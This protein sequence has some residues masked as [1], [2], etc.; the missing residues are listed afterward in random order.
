MN[1]ELLDIEAIRISFKSRM[2]ILGE[3]NINKWKYKKCVKVLKVKMLMNLQRTKQ[4]GFNSSKV[5]LTN[6]KIVIKNNNLKNMS[7][8][9]K[10]NRD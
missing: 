10:T 8:S 4:L 6:N 9:W 1:L 3:K 5:F 2:K 7:N